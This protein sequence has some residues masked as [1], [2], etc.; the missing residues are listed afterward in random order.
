MSKRSFIEIFQKAK[1]MHVKSVVSAVALSAAMLLSGTAFAQTMLGGV[2]VSAEDL[3]AVTERCE[4]LVTA[5]ASGSLT[6]SDTTA[7][8]NAGAADATVDNAPA[9]NEVE[10]ATA[11][12]DL[13]TVTL[14][15]CT[16]A[17]L[18]GAM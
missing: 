2:E 17:G 8:D 4:Q 5:E 15:Q 16:E 7:D 10:A 11:T 9:V 12:I 3:P 6:D 1:K 18:G 14:E 13:D